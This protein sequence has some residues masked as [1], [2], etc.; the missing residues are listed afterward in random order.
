VKTNLKTA[1]PE[2]P[3]QVAGPDTAN[4][5]RS[6]AAYAP[7]DG[8]FDLRIPG[9]YASRFSRINAVVVHALQL[10]AKAFATPTI[11]HFGA[12]LLLSAILNAPWHGVAGAAVVWGL[13]GLS[14]FVYE[15]IVTRRMQIQIAYTPEFEDWLFHVL[16]PFAAYTT[17]AGSRRSCPCAGGRVW[18]CCGGTAAGRYRHS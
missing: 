12:A 3:Y 8:T 13:L 15:V 5:A 16:L 7:H 6:I 18:R 11:V 4:L 10:P 17:L 9:L 1:Y 14:G 2:R